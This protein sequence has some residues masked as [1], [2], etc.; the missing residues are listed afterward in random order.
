MPLQCVVLNTWHIYIVAYN[1]ITLKTK[2][3]SVHSHF[4]QPALQ[5]S[6]SHV[7]ILEYTLQMELGKRPN[8]N[9]QWKCHMWFWA[10]DGWQGQRVCVSQ[11]CSGSNH[12]CRGTNW[13]C[14]FVRPH[15][16]TCMRLLADGSWMLTLRQ[17]GARQAYTEPWSTTNGS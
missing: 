4:N 3:C 12:C 9:H 17:A 10:W 8:K 13:S 14:L 15:T 11:P 6:S 7:D 5:H 1:Q 16:V 2:Y